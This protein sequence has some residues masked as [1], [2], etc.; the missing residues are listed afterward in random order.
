M[1]WHAQALLRPIWQCT[2]VAC[3]VGHVT[4]DVLRC[5]CRWLCGWKWG[6]IVE[7]AT[8]LRLYAALCW[9]VK[10]RAAMVLHYGVRYFVVYRV[11]WKMVQ[12]SECAVLRDFDCDTLLGI[13]WKERYMWFGTLFNINMHFGCKFV[14][15]TLHGISNPP[16]RL[17]LIPLLVRYRKWC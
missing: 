3:T 14:L 1:L 12:V 7:C 10:L 16:Y 2:N 8:L 17:W 6:E 15:E 9:T 4:C 11:G 13:N 5:C